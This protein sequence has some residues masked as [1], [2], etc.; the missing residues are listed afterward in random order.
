[1]EKKQPTA[2]KPGASSF[3]IKTQLQ[4]P[5]IARRIRKVRNESGNVKSFK[6]SVFIIYAAPDKE[7][8]FIKQHQ[9]QNADHKASIAF[10]RYFGISSSTV[11]KTTLLIFRCVMNIRK[12]HMMTKMLPCN[13]YFSIPILNH[14]VCLPALSTSLEAIAATIKFREA[15]YTFSKVTVCSLYL[16]CKS[17]RE[18]IS[19]SLQ[20]NLTH[21]AVRGLLPPIKD[22]KE[23]HLK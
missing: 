16:P 11:Q 19:F 18:N 20:M 15:D 17:S 14:M 5:V 21:A 23:E 13:C 12:I 4:L 6:K 10:N 8:K 3:K 22:N 9:G 2:V 1:M 7:I